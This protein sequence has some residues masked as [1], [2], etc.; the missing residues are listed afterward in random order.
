VNSVCGYCCYAFISGIPVA[1]MSVA[2]VMLPT[3]LMPSPFISIPPMKEL[4]PVS[5][6]MAAAVNVP[7]IK[8]V[9]CDWGGS[10]WDGEKCLKIGLKPRL[11]AYR[12]H[13]Y[14]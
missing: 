11:A 10:G 8:S 5:A 9:M 7:V 4:G 6:M 3:S 1:V 13:R 12:W 2:P 14:R